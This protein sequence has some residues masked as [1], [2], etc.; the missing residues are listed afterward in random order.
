MPDLRVPAIMFALCAALLGG[1]QAAADDPFYKGKRLSLIINFA[2]GGP[3]DIEGR[4]L[5]KHLARHIDGHPGILV[6]TSASLLREDHIVLDV[7]VAGD[8]E[9]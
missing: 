9:R 2:A 5:A 6:H 1:S 8:R 4:L 3:T 7:K